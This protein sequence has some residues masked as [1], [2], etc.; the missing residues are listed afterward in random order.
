[1]FGLGG[2]VGGGGGGER[3]ASKI[4][5]VKWKKVHTEAILNSYIRTF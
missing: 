5:A 4:I 1:M 2:G 3:E